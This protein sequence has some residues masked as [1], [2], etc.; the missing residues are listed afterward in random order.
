[1]FTAPTVETLLCCA[2]RVAHIRDGE[3]GCVRAIGSNDHA[4]DARN[5]RTVMS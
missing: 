5:D 3:A 1:L 4:G 2:C